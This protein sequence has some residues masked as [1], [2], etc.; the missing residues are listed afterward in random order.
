[1]RSKAT[2]PRKIR[3]HGVRYFEPVQLTKDEYTHLQATFAK[4][5]LITHNLGI[6]DRKYIDQALSAE[7]EGREVLVIESDITQAIELSMRVFSGVHG[8]LFSSVVG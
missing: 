7:S 3:V 5:H 1:M 6:V 4:R 2:K 8:A